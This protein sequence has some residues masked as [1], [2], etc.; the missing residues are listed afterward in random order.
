[1]NFFEVLWI[2]LVG[3]ASARILVNFR[4]L[5]RHLAKRSNLV[6]SLALWCCLGVIGLAK[7]LESANSLNLVAAAA[8]IVVSLWDAVASGRGTASSEDGVA[9]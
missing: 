3:A 8:A 9:N 1:M 7:L 2:C 6:V 4:A 5:G